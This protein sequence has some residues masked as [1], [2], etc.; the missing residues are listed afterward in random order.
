MSVKKSQ[1]NIF[2]TRTSTLRSI[3]ASELDPDVMYTWSVCL[4]A[5]HYGLQSYVTW[6]SILSKST[7]LKFTFGRAKQ[8]FYRAANSV[9][10]KI[11]RF[12][13]EKVVIELFKSK[14]LPML[15]CTEA[16]KMS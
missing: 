10:G 5:V 6:V 4:V 8:H 15:Y 2:W 9:F 1:I 13:S 11:G 7:S 14:C 3:A 16:C 12:A